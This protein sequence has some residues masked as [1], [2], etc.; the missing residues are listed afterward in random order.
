MEYMVHDERYED[1]LLQALPAVYERVQFTSYDKQGF[2]LDNIRYMVQTM[3]VDNISRYFNP[4]PTEGRSI[5]M[6]V[7]GHNGSEA[8]CNCRKGIE[9]PLQD[10]AILK[11]KGY[12]YGANYHAQP[13]RSQSAPRDGTGSGHVR[14]REDGQ[15]K[16]CSFHKSNT[17]SDEECR[18]Q[19]GT[20]LIIGSADYAILSRNPAAHGTYVL[21]NN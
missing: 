21:I 1:I 2:G 6:Q 9:H 17:R 14:Q 12:Q 8:K 20:K 16:W 15:Q 5:T 18:L 3:Y 13:Q 19:L 7:A 4:K 11:M 10:C